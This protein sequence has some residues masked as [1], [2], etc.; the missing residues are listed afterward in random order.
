[1]ATTGI[2]KFEND[3]ASVNGTV[4][5]LSGK[6]LQLFIALCN[7]QHRPIPKNVLFYTLFP[8]RAGTDIS[9]RDYKLLES[10]ISQL[11]A[12]IN[13]STPQKYYGW[14]IE[15]AVD[16][17]LNLSPSLGQGVV[18]FFGLTLD[19]ETGVLVNKE[20]GKNNERTEV[21]YNLGYAQKRLLVILATNFERNVSSKE[22]YDYIYRD[23][24]LLGLDGNF[25]NWASRLSGLASDL[26]KKLD[27]IEIGSGALIE[28]IDGGYRLT[29]KPDLTKTRRISDAAILAHEED[30]DEEDDDTIIVG[31]LSL[32]PR[33]RA[34]FSSDPPTNLLERSVVL[35]KPELTLLK[36]LSKPGNYTQY[37]H[38]AEI[39]KQ[40]TGKTHRGYDAGEIMAQAK[41]LAQKINGILKKPFIHVEAEAF[42]VAAGVDKP[43]LTVDIAKA[44]VRAELLKPFNG[45]GIKRYGKLEMD[46]SCHV[47]RHSDDRENKEPII[48]DRIPGKLLAYLLEN[49]GRPLDIDD[50]I[51]AIDTSFET[52]RSSG[53]I[54][55]LDATLSAMGLKGIIYTTAST[56]HIMLDDSVQPVQ[57]ENVRSFII[58]SD[59]I[60]STG[61]MMNLVS[62][63]RDIIETMHQA[64]GQ[65]CRDRLTP[66]QG[67]IAKTA[68]LGEFKLREASPETFNNVMNGI[69]QKLAN[70]SG[71][72]TAVMRNFHGCYRFGPDITFHK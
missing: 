71:S 8:E 31:D 23:Y 37:L 52:L 28:T 47:I 63:Q 51:K 32:S 59:N 11:R 3:I 45:G 16:G 24:R 66:E 12:E 62:W 69:A 42:S 10:H 26:V 1:M 30:F 13:K 20:I 4:I 19:L 14:M 9:K 56:S 7:S 46:M 54:K 40:K 50:V 5:R 25:E 72:P 57:A 21:P 2:F 70:L 39:F 58:R 44:K 22:I 61:A 48:L 33:S 53:V 6:K 49:S 27:E 15:S 65:I 55:D 18:T 68:K 29:K 41:S 64:A 17:Y 60:T 35:T 38:V 36:I 43:P 67:L 34:V